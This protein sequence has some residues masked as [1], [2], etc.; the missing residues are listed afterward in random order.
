MRPYP[1][2]SI[3][4]STTGRN[5]A[6]VRQPS[7]SS[8]RIRTVN[9]GFKS[10]PRTASTV[11]PAIS[12]TRPRTSTGSRPRA[13]EDRIIRTCKALPAAA[14]IA[15]LLIPAPAQ[16]LARSSNAART[17]LEARAAAIDGNHTRSAQL[18]ARL[19]DG[20][21]ANQTVTKQALSQAI[22]AGDMKLALRL[23]RGLPAAETPIEARMLQ[24]AEALRSKDEARALALLQDRSEAGDLGFVRP[25][26]QA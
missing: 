6:T 13:V 14:V 4:R 16:A 19:V 8:S 22:N 10:M 1:L 24:V 9:P 17:Y 5:S 2:R 3:W 25:F 26:V 12:R 11:R 18:L 15:A 23:V 7:T 20:S 21:V